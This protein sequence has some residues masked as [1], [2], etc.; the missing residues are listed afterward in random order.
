MIV[1]ADAEYDEIHPLAGE[2]VRRTGSLACQA[3]ATVLRH[4]SL[5]EL[6][7]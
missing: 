5:Y 1:V 3:N 4:D 7:V 6:D 2:Q